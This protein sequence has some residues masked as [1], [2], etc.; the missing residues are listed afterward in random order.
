M[1]CWSL[2]AD[3]RRDFVGRMRRGRMHSKQWARLSQNQT[4][5]WAAINGERDWK[6]PRQH[7][8]MDTMKLHTLAWRSPLCASR[9][10]HHTSHIKCNVNV[11]LNNSIYLHDS[12]VP[13]VQSSPSTVKVLQVASALKWPQNGRILS[14]LD[15]SKCVGFPA[16]PRCPG[17]SRYQILTKLNCN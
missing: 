12:P 14:E 17:K 7:S 4:P 6:S 9:S 11:Q 13:P 16:G 1:V 3:F 8:T 2:L 10:T 5:D 15:D